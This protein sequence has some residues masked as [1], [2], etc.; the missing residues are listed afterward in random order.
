MELSKEGFREGGRRGD[1]FAGV[2]ADY[3]RHR[4]PYSSPVI[5]C[6]LAFAGSDGRGRLLDVGCGTGQV[7]IPLAKHFREVIAIDP[8]EEM[9][10]FSR[11]RISE[12]GLANVSLKRL[13][14]EEISPELGKFQLVV[15][16]ASFHWMDRER[17]A[18]L[19]YDR[20]EAGGRLVVISYPSLNT[21]SAEWSAAIRGVIE[22]S[23]GPTRRAGSGVYVPGELHEEVLRRTRFGGSVE[24][25][26]VIIEEE[27]SLDRIVGWLF[28]TSFASRTLLQ[29]SAD[30]FEREIRRVVM[31]FTD[32][33][34]LKREMKYTLIAARREQ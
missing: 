20:L 17:T 11:K 13:R 7:F 25:R 6:L 5:D 4:L 15:F 23:L 22:R 19:V 12:E 3:D 1:L 26:A 21:E 33:G 28:S 31:P 34:F 16:G 2:A 10:E 29:N 14:G 18:E 8:S 27:W 24:E 32:E 30:D 9:L